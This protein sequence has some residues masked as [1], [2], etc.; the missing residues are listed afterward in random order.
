[1]A[2]KAKKKETMAKTMKKTS[3]KTKNINKNSSKAVKKTENKKE[4]VGKEIKTESPKSVD[5]K[6]NE[7]KKKKKEEKTDKG[8]LYILGGIAL[9]LLIG[10][11]LFANITT[12]KSSEEACLSY[13]NDPALQFPCTCVPTTREKNESDMVDVKTDGVCTCICDIGNNQTTVIEVRKAKK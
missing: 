10:A 5:T 13:Q 2:D 7:T 4:T 9:L 11:Y 1:M 12:E 6:K 3:E 8:F